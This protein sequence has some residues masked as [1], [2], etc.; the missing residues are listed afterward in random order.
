VLNLSS[1]PH[2]V[3]P[4]V[5]VVLRLGTAT[6]QSVLKAVNFNYPGKRQRLVI[7]CRLA[8]AREQLAPSVV[9]G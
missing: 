5:L 9:T 2:G 7:G 6:P 8:E 1:A 3:Q 4:P